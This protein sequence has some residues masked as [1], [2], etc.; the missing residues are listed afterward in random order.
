MSY[1]IL[2]TGSRRWVSTS[3]IDRALEAVAQRAMPEHAAITVVHG[4]ANGADAIAGAWAREM[5]ADGWPVTEE[6]HPAVW[7]TGGRGAGMARN[8]RMV[9]LGADVCVAFIRDNSPG[10]SA[11]AEMARRKGI[12]VIVVAWERRGEEIQP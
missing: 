9:A 3:S 4:A 12:P 5:A 6:P 7:S 10:A 8:A 2:V 11:C 1:R